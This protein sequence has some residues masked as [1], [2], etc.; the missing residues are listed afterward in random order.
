M[1]RQNSTRSIDFVVFAFV[2]IV[3]VIRCKILIIYKLEQLRRS[4]IGVFKFSRIGST[5][6]KM[7]LASV[8]LMGL[9]EIA[10]RSDERIPAV[11]A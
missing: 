10:G 1:L 11:F 9:D 4:Y 6:G 2:A 7:K 5:P 3:V 8:A